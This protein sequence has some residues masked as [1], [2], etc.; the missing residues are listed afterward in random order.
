M[1]A[2]KSEITW[3]QHEALAEVRGCKALLTPQQYDTLRWQVMA[4]DV[5]GA[6]QELR[7]ILERR[8]RGES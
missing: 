5:Y 2:M 8:R 7:K 1:Q 3:K 6:M 4:G